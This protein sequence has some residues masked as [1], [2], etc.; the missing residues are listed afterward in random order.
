MDGYNVTIKSSAEDGKQQTVSCHHLRHAIGIIFP[1]KYNSLVMIDVT[2]LA[3]TP[4][5]EEF[6]AEKSTWKQNK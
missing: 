1:T 4:L 3:T 2:T 5:R 6:G